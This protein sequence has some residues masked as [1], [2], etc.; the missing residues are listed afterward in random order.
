[1]QN[2]VLDRNTHKGSAH[3]FSSFQSSIRQHIID[4]IINSQIRDSGAGL[5]L[6]FPLAK[7]GIKLRSPIH[8]HARLEALFETW[9]NFSDDRNW[10][11]VARENGVYVPDRTN[12]EEGEL[13]PRIQRLYQ[14]V[15]FLPLD[16]IEQYYGEK[17]AFYFAWLQHCS[18]Q[19]ILPSVLGIMV[20][21]FQVTSERREDNWILPLFSV[22]L[23]SFYCYLRSCPGVLTLALKN[24]EG[25]HHGLVVLRDDFVEEETKRS[26]SPMG[27][28]K[29]SGR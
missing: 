12:G 18:I 9:Y 23:S 29:I 19:L 22:S 28:H 4:Y 5:S 16:S 13:P 1:M 24:C 17:V 26:D 2:D 21:I 3:E 20:F 11:V 27:N 25:V 10:I 14:K 7:K 15:F 8:M 6:R